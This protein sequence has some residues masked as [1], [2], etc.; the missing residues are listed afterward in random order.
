MNLQDLIDQIQ[1]KTA[2]LAV[3]GL[4]YVGLP[5]AAEFARAGFNV[6]GVEQRQERV[7]YINA[8]QTPIEGDEPGLAGLVNE[9]IRS[10]R[11]R[12]T[13]DYQELKDR[14][15]VLIA[16]ETPVDENHLPNSQA[17]QD[18][19]QSLGKVMLPGT[20]VIIESTI[21]PGTME[22]FVRPLLDASS[23]LQLNQGYYLGNCP[24]R[25]MPGKLLANLRQVSRVVGGMSS[26]TAQAMVALYRHIVQADLDATDCVTAELVKTVENAYR[27]V[28]IAFANE[29]ALI[30]EGVGG[31]VWTVRELV[32]KSPY[33]QMHLPGA[34]VGGHCIPKDPWL[35]AYS[36]IQKDVPVRLIPAAR[37]INDSMPAHVAALLGQALAEKGRQLAGALILILG[38]AYLENSDD[39]RASP[40]ASL[41]Q[42]LEA[43][44]AHLRIHDPYLNEFQ[45]DLYALA[46]G[47]DAVVLM[48][49]HQAYLDLDYQKLAGALCTPLVIDGRNII[50]R[51]LAEACGLV[52]RIIGTEQSTTGRVG[53]QFDMP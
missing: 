46:Q 9:Q 15:V 16:V 40:S 23:R 7:Q 13:H 6:L 8:G 18:A 24:E 2:R 38:Y 42:I 3:I 33:R 49:R 20:L 34:G 39:T 22:N 27:D 36:A 47:C 19:L 26:E 28:Q 10:G 4:G 43:Q 53:T 12:A 44:N 17:L 52:V 37:A 30:C 25:V 29:I 21:A 1:H 32:N 45:G 41:A 48:V 31:N 14:N 35:L 51:K 11:L 50:H 5:V